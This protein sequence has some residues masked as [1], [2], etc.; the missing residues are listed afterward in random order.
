MSTQE[1]KVVFL[2]SKKS[3]NN[4]LVSLRPISD[5]DALRCC[6]WV[7]D[8]E[9]RSLIAP[10]FPVSEDQE[11]E[12]IKQITNPSGMPRNIVLGV[13][14]NNHHV[15]MIGLHDIDYIHRHAETG[16]LIGEKTMRQKGIG[17]TAKQLLI[18][19]AFGELGMQNLHTRV[20]D[21][22]TGSKKL[23]DK[24]GWRHVGTY[25]NFYLKGGN[26]VDLLLYQL[27][28]QEWHAQKG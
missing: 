11:H 19:Y 4:G 24:C 17:S 23:Q 1:L 2:Q 20:H 26:W 7:N 13:Y 10:V 28:Y 8:P 15:G 5:R 16:L 3:V 9:N 21:N 14:H 27:T 12:W 22:N 18:D 25:S 6:T